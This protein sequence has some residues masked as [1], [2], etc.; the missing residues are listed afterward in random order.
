MLN[1]LLENYEYRDGCLYRTTVRGGEA[2]GKKAGWLTVCN[3]KQYWKLSVM[4]KTVY[5]H[6][7]IFLMHHKYV[8]KYIDHI[9]G[10][11][12][13]NKI[14]NLREATQSQN[15]AN[16]KLNSANTSG[17]KGVT[18]RKDTKKWAAQIMKNGKHISLGCYKTK[19]D[20]YQAYIDGAKK[21][22]GEFARSDQANDRRQD[23][24]MQ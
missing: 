1:Y 21:H 16:S 3:K 15:A 13:N 5:L 17:F 7:A 22:Y 4:K 20:A 14:E 11:S 10:V 23:R 8:P 9:D 12:T 18:F 2:I 24:T 6:Q 19:E